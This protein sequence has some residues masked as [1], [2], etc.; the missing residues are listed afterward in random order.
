[1]DTP[2]IFRGRKFVE[3]ITGTKLNNECIMEG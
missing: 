1:M 2:G 3:R